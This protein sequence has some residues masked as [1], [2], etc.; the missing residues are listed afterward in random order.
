MKVKQT[1]MG[2]WFSNDQFGQRS[3]YMLYGH[4]AGKN[5]FMIK[6][7]TA[8]INMSAINHLKDS[9]IA[10][11][12]ETQS[13]EEYY[14]IFINEMK[15]SN[16]KQFFSREFQVSIPRIDFLTEK[17]KSLAQT[18]VQDYFES[19]KRMAE[20]NEEHIFKKVSEDF[21]HEVFGSSFSI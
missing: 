2:K 1:I 17:E 18:Y 6:L 3:H 16:L 10:K 7:K 13:A 5:K 9:I 19:F 4:E 15:L 12:F 8:T 21:Q 11:L 14:E 20:A